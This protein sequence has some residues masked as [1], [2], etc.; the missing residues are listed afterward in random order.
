MANAPDI[1]HVEGQP[2]VY[3]SHSPYPAPIYDRESETLNS[4]PSL[5]EKIYYNL[6]S[7]SLYFPRGDFGDERL[8][9]HA[10]H[11]ATAS[12]R[13]DLLAAAAHPLSSYNRQL[14][15]H[16]SDL[17][18]S[19]VDLYV[20]AKERWAATPYSSRSDSLTHLP[21]HLASVSHMPSFELD[22]LLPS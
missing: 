1:Y 16:M 20:L 12:Y 7:S 8:N 11:A 22:S 4:L 3:I 6:A 9:S 13:I 5:P 2:L 10:F 21:W 18:Q 19:F 14:S 17:A 15:S